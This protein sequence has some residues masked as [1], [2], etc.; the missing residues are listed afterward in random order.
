M[1]RGEMDSYAAL[2]ADWNEMKKTAG[3]RAVRGDGIL[4]PESRDRLLQRL[5]ILEQR[6]QFLGGKDLGDPTRNWADTF[7]WLRAEI[8]QTHVAENTDAP[9]DADV[10][11]PEDAHPA[12]H[13]AAHDTY[14]AMEA[15][16]ARLEDSPAYR[17]M[18]DRVGVSWDDG[19]YLEHA[20]EEFTRRF[21]HLAHRGEDPGGVD[22]LQRLRDY[23]RG[24]KAVRLA[25]PDTSIDTLET[26][27]GL[28]G[29]WGPV[30]GA[31][32]LGE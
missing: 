24:L 6:N 18:L 29:R 27:R 14:A 8:A 19:E 4:L 17:R 9:W 21:E 15:D 26:L 3:Y 7:H 32:A 22:W 10:A 20:L 13:R 12:L 30:L 11:P 5:A 31:D 16:W 23:E 2:R 1:S 28:I 25:G